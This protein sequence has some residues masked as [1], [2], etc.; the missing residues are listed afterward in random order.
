M[1]KERKGA[2][3]WMRER[4]RGRRQGEKTVRRAGGVSAGCASASTVE[5]GKQLREQKNGKQ[6]RNCCNSSKL[7]PDREPP[8]THA[9]AGVGSRRD[10]IAG[11]FCS[12]TASSASLHRVTSRR[13]VDWP[14]LSSANGEIKPGRKRIRVGD[15]PGGVFHFRGVRNARR[16]TRRAATPIVEELRTSHYA[17]AQSVRARTDELERV[18]CAV[19]SGILAGLRRLST[20]PC[21]AG[22]PRRGLCFLTVSLRRT[23]R[24]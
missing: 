13:P 11:Q 15:T 19:A 6:L 4:N 8:P 24:L 22:R 21:R 7:P 9:R 10:G 12:L 17:G 3:R 23:M 18:A 14:A 16:W 1:E 2:D 5:R 20:I